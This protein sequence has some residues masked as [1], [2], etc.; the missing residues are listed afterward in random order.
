MK[1]VVIETVSV[2][3]YGVSYPAPEIIE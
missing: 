2:E 1:P 3:T